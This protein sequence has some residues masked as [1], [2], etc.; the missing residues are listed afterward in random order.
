MKHSG[1]S[2]LELSIVIAILGL[3]A[4]GTMV[5]FELMRA[6]SLRTVM[7]EMV[8]YEAAVVTFRDKYSAYPGDMPNATDKWGIA[9]G[10]TGSEAACQN[11]AS[12]PPANSNVAATCNG[13]GDGKIMTS[14]TVQFDETVRAWQHLKNAELVEGIFA[15]TVNGMAQGDLLT[16]IVKPSRRQ[17]VAYQFFTENKTY[18][19]G[20][21]TNIPEGTAS[22]MVLRAGGTAPSTTGPTL[23]PRIASNAFS[24]LDAY[25]ID[26]KLDDKKPGTGK[27]F[28]NADTTNC[29]SNTN[30]LTAI[31]K[32]TNATTS[33]NIGC[34]LHYGIQ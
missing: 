26:E 7:A 3:L 13:N 15:G 6:A 33:Q 23:P 2:L 24:P 19:G 14:T 32:T 31:Y 28:P 30:A 9:G 4:G 27:I 34:Y 21:L 25:T 12:Y 29:T 5:G 18:L 1:F 8:Q 16:K 11:T 17:G 20:W 22:I 10:T